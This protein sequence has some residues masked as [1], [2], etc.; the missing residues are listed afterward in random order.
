MRN[1]RKGVR[2]P[3]GLARQV[4]SSL[5]K[6]GGKPAMD[7]LVIG[8]CFTFIG[9]AVAALA[10]AAATRPESLRSSAQ[11]E[12]PAAKP[13]ARFFSE[14]LTPPAPGPAP[15]QVPIEVLLMQI[16]SHVRLE[17][18]AAESFVAYP[19]HAHLHS[20]TTSPLVN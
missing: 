11:P 7:M 4:L 15:M 3:I 17:Q 19:T 2:R 10:F 1:E 12:Q 13:P 8:L 9:L 18:A 16:E 5:R 14:S 20:K 6:Q